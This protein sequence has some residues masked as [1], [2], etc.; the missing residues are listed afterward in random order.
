MLGLPE[1]E[2]ILIDL[3]DRFFEFKKPENMTEVGSQ[4]VLI[5]IK[6]MVLGK[7]D[8]TWYEPKQE[9]SPNAE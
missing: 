5:Y 4:A 7:I 9:E 3:M 8:T 2:M 1:G 6:N